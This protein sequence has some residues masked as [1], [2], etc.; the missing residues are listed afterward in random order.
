MIFF[1][2]GSAAVSA[3]SEQTIDNMVKVRREVRSHIQVVGH[4][5]SAGSRPHNLQLSRRRAE[6]VKAALVAKGFP[7]RQIITAGR[8]ESYAVVETPDATAEPQNRRVEVC[9]Y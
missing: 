7:K 1:D 8:G 9:F 2:S 3:Q 6:S 5:D 4:A